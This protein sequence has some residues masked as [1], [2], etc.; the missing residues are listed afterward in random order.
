MNKAETMKAL[1]TIQEVYP[2]FMDGRTPEKTADIWQKLFASE[3]YAIVS[4]AIVAF[5]T[6]DTRG[7]PPNIGQIK[8]KIAQMRDDEPDEIQAWALVCKAMSCASRAEFAKLPP[9]IQQC[10]GSPETLIEWGNTDIGIVD[11]VTAAAFMRTYRARAQ[12]QREYGKLPEFARQ[13]YP[14]L[15]EQEPYRLP[16]PK[17]AEEWGGERAAAPQSVMDIAQ[18]IK[19]DIASSP[20]AIQEL[21]DQA[22]RNDALIGVTEALLKGSKA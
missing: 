12:K 2:H 13:N 7:F 22:R 16:E 6:S 15:A 5:I 8:E 17:Q 21:K 10:V 3:P 9:L 11:T 19:A 1:S 14:A 18:K 20:R 4:A